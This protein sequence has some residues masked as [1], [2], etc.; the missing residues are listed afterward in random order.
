LAPE[1]I[2]ESELKVFQAEHRSLSLIL[3]E[4]DEDGRVGFWTRAA[5]TEPQRFTQ[6]TLN[7]VG[8]RVDWAWDQVIEIVKKSDSSG[9]SG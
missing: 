1:K 2:T 5:E 7:Q 3:P 4:I 6:I 9:T 8:N